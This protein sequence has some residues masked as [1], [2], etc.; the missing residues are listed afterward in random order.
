M[1][2]AYPA[3]RKKPLI[4][5]PYAEE[6]MHGFEYQAASHMIR[7]GLVEEGLE[8]VRAVRNRYDGKKRNPWNEMECGSNYVR[9]L[10]S[11]AL[12]LVYSGFIYDLYR[13]RIGFHPIEEGDY[14]F[15]W[16]V[17]TGF[18]T[19][20]KE[21][22]TA[23]LHVLYGKLEVGEFVTDTEGILEV[24]SG[25]KPVQYSVQGDTVLFDEIQNLDSGRDITV[26]YK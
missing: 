5:V 12:L 15:F 26:I 23:R 10:A 9:S 25:E 1:I 21:N 17:D 11:Y 19:I 22:K 7:H 20:Q 16:S 24:L 14:Q 6:T 3:D 18:G 13:H 4:P 2:C 8:C